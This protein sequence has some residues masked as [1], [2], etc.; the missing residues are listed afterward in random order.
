MR[1]YHIKHEGLL[2]LIHFQLTPRR[3]LQKRGATEFLLTNLEVF[4]NRMK[5]CYTFASFDFL[6]FNSSYK[7]SFF[8]VRLS[9]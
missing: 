2:H 4:E 8:S 7:P 9:G 1:K 6:A 3:W 5:H